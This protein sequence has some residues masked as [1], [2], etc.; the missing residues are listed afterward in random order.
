M[1]LFV[2]RLVVAQQRQPAALSLGAIEPAASDERTRGINAVLHADIRH[3]LH[4]HAERFGS[5]HAV[6]TA[7]QLARHDVVR[8]VVRPVNV[9]LLAQR[10]DVML[11][12][13]A[14]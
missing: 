5:L 3:N 9:W 7:A 2:P 13:F 10:F 14:T 4:L 8:S 1:A 12:S 11:Q 6:L